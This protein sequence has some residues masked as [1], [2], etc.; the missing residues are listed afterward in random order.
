MTT[1]STRSKDVGTCLG[2]ELMGVD[3]AGFQQKSPAAQEDEPEEPC[4]D[5]EGGNDACCQV[6]LMHYYAEDS[7]QH[8][9]CE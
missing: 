6:E 8:C 5:V 7:S 4:S 2:S 9:S 3:T 1:T